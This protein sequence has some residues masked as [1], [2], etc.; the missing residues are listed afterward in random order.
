MKRRRGTES[1]RITFSVPEQEV[2]GGE[3]IPKFGVEESGREVLIYVNPDVEPSV[4][5]P[6]VSE[7]ELREITRLCFEVIDVESG[8]DND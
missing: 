7:A 6:E 3:N 5:K 8:S 4:E 1:S 2:I